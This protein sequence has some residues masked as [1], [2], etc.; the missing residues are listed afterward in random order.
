M[1]D[2]IN[3]QPEHARELIKLLKGIPTLMN[4]IPFNPFEGSGYRSSPKKAVLR[5]SEILNKAGMTTVV[6]KTRGDDID[7]ACGQLAGRIEDKSRRHRR[8][9]EPRFGME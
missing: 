6:R 5:F 3:D 4:L 9:I 7:A 1:L 8:F 2:G